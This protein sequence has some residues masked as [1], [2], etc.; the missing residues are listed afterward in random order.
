MPTSAVRG[1]RASGPQ[2]FVYA[3]DVFLPV[4]NFGEA[5]AWRATDWIRWVQWLVIACGWGL[6]TVFVAGFTR[7]V[8]N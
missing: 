3:A 7:V 1:V 2:P 4:I 6:T 8:R 5:D